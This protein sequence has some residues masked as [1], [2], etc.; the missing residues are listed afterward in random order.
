MNLF[1]VTI[2][3]ILFTLVSINCICQTNENS[4]LEFF[5]LNSFQNDTLYI[6]SRFIECGEWG[7]HIELSRIYIQGKDFYINYEKF[8]ADCNTIKLNNGEPRQILVSTQSKKLLEKHKKLIIQY[9]HQLLNAKLR[10]ANPFHFGYT[11]EIKNTDRSIQIF[12]YTL[13]GQAK[14]EY[15]SFINQVFQ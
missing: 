7:G 5:D 2:L 11:F 1:R 6:R 14:E 3:P 8:S 13:A 12:V 4:T 10:E 9:F 15:T